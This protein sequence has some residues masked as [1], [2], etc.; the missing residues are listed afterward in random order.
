MVLESDSAGI[1]RA[2]LR[3]AQLL[4]AQQALAEILQAQ[5]PA[6][7]ILQELFRNNRQCGSRDRALVGELVYGVLRDLRRLQ[8]LAGEATEATD[9]QALLALQALVAGHADAATLQAWGVAEA[10][11]LAQRLADFDAT[12]LAPAE[13]LNLPDDTHARLLAQ[14]GAGE[15][16]AL[17]RAL[18]QPATVDLRV[19]TLKADRDSVRRRLAEDG[20]PAEPTPLSPLGLRLP[21]RAPLQNLALF[22]E[23]W[24]EPQDEGS[25]LIALLVGAAPGETVID[26]CAG[27]GGKTLALAAQ[28]RDQGQLLA[29]DISAARLQRLQPRLQRAGLH[30][31]RSQLLRDEH[32]PALAALAGRCDAVLVDAPCS[33][34]GTWRRNPE[35]RLRQPDYAA[36]QAQ[37][38]SILATAARLVRPGGRLVYATCSLMAE[39]N[40]QVVDA[41]LAAQPQFA[42]EDAGALL[43]RQGAAWDGARL[44]LLP[45]VHGT[46]GFF[47]AALRRQG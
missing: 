33:A 23:G 37:Q 25:Q 26:F 8:S 32:D 17:A 16:A 38:G 36:L 7:V 5:R 20:L 35:L 1:R 12:R 21:G 6:D 24:I 39:E 46:D 29:C 9:A 47:A 43:Q 27:A 41:F 40:E 3:R 13:R 34:T 18:N 4:L 10:P 44:R 30:C 11:Q 2:G 31:V 28:L 19:N 15:V 14:Y 22:R 42:E 45:Q